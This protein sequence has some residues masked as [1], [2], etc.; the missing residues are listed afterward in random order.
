MQYNRLGNTDLE[1]SPITIG[2]WQLGGPLSFNNQ[3]DGHPDPGRDNVLRMIHALG[4]QGINA[5]DTAEQ[6]G[7]GE[8]ERRVGAAIHDRRDQ[9]VVSTKF[10]FR[11]GP[12]Q[13]RIDDSSPGS[14]LNSIEG[15]LGRL[16]TDHIDILLYHCPPSPEELPEAKAVLEQAKQ[17]GKIRYYGISCNMLPLLN[18]M[19]ALDMLD[20][21]QLH[22]NL[23]R[24]D[25]ATR[26]F[27]KKHNI[28]TQ[29]RGI[30]AE[31]RLSGRYFT[32]Q[33]AWAS[34]DNRSKS[35]I[36]Y[37]RYAPLQQ[38]I[39]EGRTMAETVL[40][41]ALDDPAVH[42]IC[43]GAKKLK[44]YQTALKACELPALTPEQRIVLEQ[45]ASQLSDIN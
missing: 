16:K 26:N 21:V 33:P 28:G 14:I 10:G 11:V 41:W 4:D 9:W 37:T 1:V 43:M 36:D 22:S 42:T 7:G 32:Q 5:I 13:S 25:V 31:G 8:S 27:L 24:N 39:P 38:A 15:S 18:E 40:R 45:L 19:Q 2:A 44:D 35:V 23:L 30:M 20:V 6:Y 34:D 29:M 3:P 17:D 12:G